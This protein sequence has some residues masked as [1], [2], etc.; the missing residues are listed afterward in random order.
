MALG[1]RS[2]R[3]LPAVTHWLGPCHKRL[4]VG[5]KEP[6]A[7]E[8]PPSLDSSKSGCVP[9]GGACDLHM[10]PQEGLAGGRLCSRGLGPVTGTRPS[11]EGRTELCLVCQAVTQG[12]CT[13]FLGRG[14]GRLGLGKS[15]GSSLTGGQPHSDLRAEGLSPSG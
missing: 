7:F 8:T 15:M 6:P 4:T 10:C 9:K 13:W 3:L 11:A 14:W 12:V 2:R 1:G 5:K